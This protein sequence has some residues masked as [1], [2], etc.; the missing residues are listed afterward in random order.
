[1]RQEELA[2]RIGIVAVLGLAAAMLAGCAS[3]TAKTAA[4]PTTPAPEPM[5]YQVKNMADFDSAK[6]KAEKECIS[7]G[8]VAHYV[9]RTTSPTGDTVRFECKA[10]G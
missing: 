6:N 10:K 2:M 9:D 7:K 3:T 4:A 1:M 8:L 5:T